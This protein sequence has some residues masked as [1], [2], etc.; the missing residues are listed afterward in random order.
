M[1]QLYDV[2]HIVYGLRSGII[3]LRYRFI[4]FF[5]IYLYIQVYH[6]VSILYDIVILFVSGFSPHT[7]IFIFHSFQN[8]TI[9]GEGPMLDT[10][11]LV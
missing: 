9:T 2:G 3:N 6:N 10:H 4:I 11:A 5:I 1:R 7:T 8:L